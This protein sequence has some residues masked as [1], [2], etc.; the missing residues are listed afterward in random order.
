MGTDTKPQQAQKAQDTQK[1]NGNEKEK[2]GGAS[3]QGLAKRKPQDK[4]NKEKAKRRRSEKP[5]VP[6]GIHFRLLCHEGQAGAV[7]GK[8]GDTVRNIRKNSGAE[9]SVQPPIQGHRLRVIIIDSSPGNR[10][11]PSYPAKEALLTCAMLTVEGDQPLNAPDPSKLVDVRL[12][13]HSALAAGLLG[14]KHSHGS[15][16]AGDISAR[17]GANVIIP[18]EAERPKLAEADEEYLL[19]RGPWPAVYAALGM[20]ADE[21]RRQFFELRDPH[22]EPTLGPAPA[23]FGFAGPP[24]M[25]MVPGPFD[26]LEAMQ[27]GIGLGMEMAAAAAAGVAGPAPHMGGPVHGNGP[28]AGGGGGGH[29]T[30]NGGSLHIAGLVPEFRSSAEASTPIAVT[31]KLVVPESKAGR[32]IGKGGENLRDMRLALGLSTLKVHPAVKDTSVRVLEVSSTEPAASNRCAAADALLYYVERLGQ[33]TPQG[34]GGN[35][36]RITIKMLLQQQH[37]GPVVG[38]RAAVIRQISAL[39]KASCVV[40]KKGDVPPYGA[41]DD[42]ELEAE[43]DAQH[44]FEA[45]RIVAAIVRGCELRR[46]GQIAVRETLGTPEFDIVRGNIPPHAAPH[47]AMGPMVSATRAGP[48]MEPEDSWVSP[49]APVGHGGPPGGPPGP[50]MQPQHQQQMQ[51][52]HQQGQ[53]PQ[54]YH[55]HQEHPH[56][57]RYTQQAPVHPQ[58]PMQGPLGPMD[59]QQQQ[60]QQQVQLPPHLQ[61]QK[62]RLDASSPLDKGQGVAGGSVVAGLPPLGPND[63]RLTIF[64]AAALLNAPE[65]IN[66]TNVQQVQAVTN[67]VVTLRQPV[68]SGDYE[69]D[70]TGNFAQVMQAHTLLSNIMT[71]GAILQ[72]KPQLAPQQVPPPAAAA[73]APSG[74]GQPG[75]AAA[76]TPVTTASG[77]QHQVVVQPNQGVVIVSQPPPQ[78]Q[79]QPP[80]VQSPPHTQPIAAA[81]QQQQQALAP[82]HPPSAAQTQPV[83]QAVQTGPSQGAAV[84]PGANP[85]VPSQQQ[86]QQALPAQQVLPQQQAPPQQ[87]AQQQQHEQQQQVQQQQQMEQP[88]KGVPSAHPQSQQQQNQQQRSQQYPQDAAAPPRQT[89]NQQQPY[90]GQQQPFPAQQTAQ[91][92]QP[93]QPPPLMANTGRAAVPYQ[94]QIPQ[95]QQTQQQQTQQQ[96]Q[97]PVGQTAGYPQAAA[98]PVAGQPQQQYMPQQQNQAQQ[99]SYSQS[100]AQQPQVQQQSSYSQTA[101]AAQQEQ[102]HGTNPYSV[103]GASGYNSSGSAAPAAAAAAGSAQPS[104]QAPA[105]SSYGGQYSQAAAALTSSSPAGA[106]PAGPGPV[107]TATASY[108]QQPQYAGYG[109]AGYHVA[110]QPSH[111][112]YQQPQQQQQP[113]APSVH[114]QYYMHMQQQYAAYQAAAAAATAAATYTPAAYGYGYGPAPTAAPQ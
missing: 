114:D 42:Q 83:P 47:T 36:G 8:G 32:F 51:M 37:C 105:T 35:R 11:V 61:K 19:L 33:N 5:A 26:P 88:G 16:A 79:Q 86:Q 71:I 77:A 65:G 108:A 7:I 50:S 45:I 20:V 17:C 40:H 29:V 63:V 87:H 69:L 34:A 93:Q 104:G 28:M 84:Y 74:A 58:P 106:T 102:A 113:G 112:Y 57:E 67:T 25:G 54:H 76:S 66:G 111:P 55:P 46:Q 3:T 99:P 21:V 44:V 10:A 6:K 62:Q 59:Q 73:T 95:Q 80:A 48:G 72:Q 98:L 89:Q 15:L 60:Q 9:V 92:Q 82:Q 101:T 39:T 1:Q 24:P 22:V 52:Q 14:L 68:A 81:Q 13:V 90:A 75:A 12:L 30:P 53:M 43:G 100:Y 103:Y 38:P 31:Y 4:D 96:Q 109:T 70:I 97:Q 49:D 94:Q 18:G 27:L 91:S 2:T 85:N 41:P 110:P 23:A 78:Q 56:E 64:V 107:G